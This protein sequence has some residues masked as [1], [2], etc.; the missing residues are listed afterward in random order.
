MKK[1]FFLHAFISLLFL[2]Q[3]AVAQKV[4]IKGTAVDSL[5]KP[6]EL[7]TV[8]LLQAKDSALTTFT[9]TNEKGEFE[10]KNVS[11]DKY[12]LKITYVGFKTYNQLIDAT[13]AGELNLGKIQMQIQI[14]ELAGITVEAEKAPVTFKKDTLEFNAGSFKTKQN[15]VVEDLLKKLPG[16]EVNRDG[17]IKA[18]GETVQKVTVNGKDFFGNDPKIATRNLAAEAV[19]KVQVYD[20]KSDQAAFTGIDDG[21]RQ[22]TINLELKEK[23]KNGGFGNVMVGY[24]NDR[25]YENRL[26]Y[27]RFNKTS[28]ISVLGMGNN[29]NQQG[30]SIDDYMNFSGATRGMMNGGGI[31]LEING[32]DGGIPLNFGGRNY[33]FMTNWAAGANLNKT[34]NPKTEITGNYFYNWLNQKID[35]DVERKN[36]LP[37]GNFSSAQ[38]T[39]QN[40]TNSN[41]RLNLTME[42][43]LDSVNSFKLTSAFTYNQTD[44]FTSSYNKTLNAQGNLQNEGDRTNIRTGNTLRFNNDLLYRHRF[45]KKG[46]TISTNL[47][48]N[49]NE[50]DNQ[51]DL[52]AV[53]KYYLPNGNLGQTQNINQK[54]T[55]TNNTYTLGTTVSYTEPI[56]KKKYLE[57]N[58]NFRTNINKVNQEVYDIRDTEQT[59]NQNLT[60]KFDNNFLYNRVGVNYRMNEKKYNF[61]TGLS[62]QNSS[63]QGKLLLRNVDINRSFTNLLPN[64]HFNYNF[65]NAKRINLDY[66]TNVQEPNITQLQPVIDNRDPLNIY[67]GNPNLRPAYQHNLRLNYM[68]FDPIKFINFFAFV[69]TIY[70]TNFITT[71]QNID[72]QFVR[73]SMPVNVRDNL[74]VVSNVSFG[75]PIKKLNSRF[76]LSTNNTLMQGVNVLNDIENKFNQQTISGRVRYDFNWK[77]WVNLG[78]SADVSKQQ[79]KYEFNERQNQVFINQ[80]YTAE[81]NF[82]FPKGFS[83]NTDLDYLIYKS[84]TTDFKQEIPIL[85]MSI[86]KTFLKANAGELKFSV[87]NLLDQSI[88]ASQQAQV[89][90][91]EQT[92]IRS[93]GRY[94]M[95]SFTYSLNKAMNPTAG[96]RGMIKMIRN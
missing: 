59:L 42:H 27:N 4:T 7:A 50:Q 11:A 57:F 9:R 17:S 70:T 82:T 34:L 38:N 58:Y 92:V 10:L 71:A 22:K 39:S 6:L 15:A 21:Q 87:N 69:N 44:A 56:A 89:N 2:S 72:R 25:R 35:Q 41:H 81:G 12:L 14:K 68:S 79:T 54:S 8:M 28:Q 74:M 52:K 47:T 37:T 23:Y 24:G 93:L 80:T 33:G 63:I 40:N 26:S 29:V 19:D 61:S 91:L 46:R 66:E 30:F 88:G 78:L 36:F 1:I 90:Y 75:F 3:V 16:V 64:A 94:F 60:N 49:V 76:N 62:L 5:A 53:N 31:R 77:E 83:F 20:R 86:S 13:Q 45:A 73:T 32:D 48:F 96:R 65:S 51:G 85:N 18:Q 43:K 95:L 84:Q 55:T 67:V